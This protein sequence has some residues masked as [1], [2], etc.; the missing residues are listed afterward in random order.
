[1]VAA[2]SS[3][4]G[5]MSPA[6]HRTY[7]RPDGYGK[8]DVENCKMMNGAVGGGGATLSDREGPLVV[9]EGI[10]TGLSLLS[11][12]LPHAG[13]VVAALSASGVQCLRLPPR[14]QKLILAPD[15]DDAGRAAADALA[16]RA[17]TLGWTVEVVTPPQGQDFNEI[18]MKK[19]AA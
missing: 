17:Y 7:L 18:L 5:P 15:G 4:D 14:S 9:C 2:V 12:L 6:I 3:V 16:N 10:E 1:M 11:G 19:E 13:A 8:A